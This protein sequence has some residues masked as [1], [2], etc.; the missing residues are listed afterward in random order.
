MTPDLVNGVLE[1]I[2]SAF[3]W[4][5]VVRLHRDR[6]AEGVFWPTTAFFTLW[7]CWNLYYYPSLGQWVSFC[8]GLLIALGNLTWV[9]LLAWFAWKKRVH[10][11]P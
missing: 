7:G 9:A 5:N 3:I 10:R 8:G 4:M 2:G 6:Q 11:A 1:F